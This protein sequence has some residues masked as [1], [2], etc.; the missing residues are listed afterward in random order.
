MSL[1]RIIP[2]L[3]AVLALVSATLFGQA[4]GEADQ[5]LEQMASAVSTERLRE[6]IGTLASFGT[7]NTLSG[8]TSATRG[9]GAARQG[10]A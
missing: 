5:R 6:L 8:T 3:L 4:Q 7:R 1:P 2:A 10:R 9:I